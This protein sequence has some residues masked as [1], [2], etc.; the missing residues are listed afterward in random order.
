MLFVPRRDVPFTRFA[1]STNI[2]TAKR[3]DNCIIRLDR[4]YT[5]NKVETEYNYAITKDL[6]DISFKDGNANKSDND[7][8]KAN[9]L[10]AD[11]ILCCNLLL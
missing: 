11:T 10:H 6:E 2:L 7:Y 1:N 3:D 9:K 8:Q 5:R 4:N